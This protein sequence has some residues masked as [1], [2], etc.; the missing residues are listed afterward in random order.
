MFLPLKQAVLV[1]EV[2]EFT[3]ALHHA[4]PSLELILKL[5]EIVATAILIKPLQQL[6][7]VFVKNTVAMVHSFQE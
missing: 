3:H 7:K 4:V 1:I 6:L 2:R 5:I